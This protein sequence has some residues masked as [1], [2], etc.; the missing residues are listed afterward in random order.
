[1]PVID[2]LIVAT[3]QHVR[4]M[5]NAR[6]VRDSDLVPALRLVDDI[7]DDLCVAAAAG[8][9]GLG[10]RLA[11]LEILVFLARVEGEQVE[12]RDGAMAGGLREGLNPLLQ[13]F[14][15]LEALGRRGDAGFGEGASQSRDCGGRW[16][17]D[18]FVAVSEA[19]DEAGGDAGGNGPVVGERRFEVRG[20]RGG[21]LG[22]NEEVPW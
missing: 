4:E 2:L 18:A 19:V 9:N 10:E 17:Q 7:A 13:V 22:D 15:K 3:R 12:H 21:P 14:C 8:A 20:Q 16:M 1:M 11:V 6:I 5:R